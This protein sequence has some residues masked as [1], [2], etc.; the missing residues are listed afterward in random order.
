MMCF[1]QQFLCTRP[2][3]SKPFVSPPTGWS[4]PLSWALLRRNLDF[5]TSEQAGGTAVPHISQ[6]ENPSSGTFLWGSRSQ[7]RFWREKRNISSGFHGLGQCPEGNMT[8]SLPS[9]NI[10]TETSQKLHLKWLKVSQ[11][12]FFPQL[13]LSGIMKDSLPHMWNLPGNQRI[14]GQGKAL[15]FCQT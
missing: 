9:S 2:K 4:G 11:S 12:A 6:L 10:F 7:V 15:G 8:L 14:L 3:E 1:T 5:Q 13:I